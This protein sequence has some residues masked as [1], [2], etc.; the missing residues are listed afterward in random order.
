MPT[1]TMIYRNGAW[2]EVPIA[3][4][5]PAPLVNAQGLRTDG[6]TLA[7]W[8]KAG[9]TAKGYPPQGYAATTTPCKIRD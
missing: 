1:T 3:A 2:V 4:P 5:A 6:P 7:Q 8:L 9:Y